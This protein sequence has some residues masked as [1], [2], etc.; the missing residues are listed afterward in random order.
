MAADLDRSKLFN[1]K[2]KQ[3]ERDYP[4]RFIGA[5]HV[6][7]SSPP[8]NISDYGSHAAEAASP[9]FALEV[10]Q[11]GRLILPAGVNDPSPLMR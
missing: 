9:P 8:V 10:P 7:F 4:G 3:A 6:Q 5:A 2:A 1:Q 11:I